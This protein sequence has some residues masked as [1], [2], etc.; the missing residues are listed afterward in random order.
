L[1]IIAQFKIFFIYINI[2][3]QPTKQVFSSGISENMTHKSCDNYVNKFL[4]LW[5]PNF[6]V[7]QHE[8]IAKYDRLD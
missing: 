8:L 7:E 6:P 3:L 4:R 2:D 5:L 1:K